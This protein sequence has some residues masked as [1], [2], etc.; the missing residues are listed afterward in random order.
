[1]SA[2]LENPNLL[3]LAAGFTDSSSLPLVAVSA[4]VGVLAGQNANETLQYGMNQGRP[5][6]RKLLAQHLARWEPDLV[7][8]AADQRFFISNGSQQALYLALQVLCEPGDIVLVDRPSYFVFL[9]M[10][11]AM[12]VRAVS[13]PVDDA[14]R[15]DAP[16]IAALLDRLAQA[17]DSRRIKAVYLVSYFSNPSSRSLVE[18]EK[19]VLAQSLMARDLII[20]VIED[21]AYRDL[22]FSARPE[23][24]SVLTVPEWTV[25]PK[26]YLSTLTKPF[27]TG[28]KVGYG[29][30][31]D[32]E[33]LAR[34]LYTK[35]HHDFGTAN[36]N[37]AVLEHIIAD[38][39]LE[40]QLTV[41]RSLYHRKMQALHD[42]LLQEGLPE[43]GW[44]W[45]KPTGGLYLWLKAPARLDTGLDSAFYHRCITAGVL[46]VPG[47][48]CF[49]DESPQNFARLSFGVLPVV[50]LGEAARRFV[51]VARNFQG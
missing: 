31:T 46:Y 45:A 4:A 11:A 26:L 37:Q 17:G 21:A 7:D 23:A 40:R 42:T 2:A 20:P 51:Q 25:F 14:G 34:M 15:L 44:A 12:G 8:A 3:S 32:A 27:A 28:M 9:E 48:L 43:L 5:L 24:R 38:G 47:A 29:Y 6:L 16:A 22:Y 36:F 49:G 30:C 13:L 1:M 19:V 39:G 18:S 35:G 50:E 10:L 33:W 41:I